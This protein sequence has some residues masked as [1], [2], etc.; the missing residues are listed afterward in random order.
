MP[1]SG[2]AQLCR[3]DSRWPRKTRARGDTILK[4]GWHMLELVEDLLDPS[5][6]ELGHIAV[7]AEDVDALALIQECGRPR[8]WPRRAVS[9][10]QAPAAPAVPIVLHATPKWLGRRSTTCRRIA[11]KHTHQGGR[12][13]VQL[14]DLGS[15]AEISARQRPG[16]ARRPAPA[17]LPTLRAAGAEKTGTPGTGMGLALVRTLVELMAAASACTARWA[18]STFSVNPPPRFRRRPRARRT[19]SKDKLAAQR[20][21][22]FNGA[23]RQRSWSRHEASASFLPAWAALVLRLAAQAVTR[24]SCWPSTPHRP[25]RRA[26][27]E[28]VEVVHHQLRPRLRL[29][30]LVPATARRAH[31]GTGK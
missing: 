5:A 21:R 6:A 23:V 4:S 24:P 19:W 18:G 3:P 26:N 14:A 15:S 29:E 30:L 20:P 31:V 2:F 11:I 12:A 28:G 8:C 16:A 22:C 27:A 1:S 13:R 17:H 7:Q 9:N 10:W 25:V